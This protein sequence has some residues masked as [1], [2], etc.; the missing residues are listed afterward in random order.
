ML[1]L[2]GAIDIHVHAA[3][4]LFRRVGDAVDLA[5]AARDAGMAGLV[6][7][8]H[9]ESTVTRAY[10]TG[11]Q[12]PGIELYGGIVLNGFVGGFNPMAAAA[13]LHQ[14]ARIIWGPTMH[15]AHQVER[16]GAGT[17]GVG[18]MTLPPELASPGLRALDESG[19]LVAEL[20][21]IIELAGRFDATIATGHLGPDEVRALVLACREAGVRCL[22]T[23]VYFLDKSSEFLLEMARAGALLEVSASVS[24][25]L[26]HYLL[27]KHGGGMRLEDVAELVSAVGAEQIVISSDCG[28]IHNSSPTEALRSFLNAVKAVGVSEDDINTMTR[29]TPRK[30]LG[31]PPG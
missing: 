7:K 24:F 1:T 6:F 19:R 5:T 2:E 25:P 17:Y 11:L 26:E 12:V 21:E 30:I 13:A 16:F 27:R 14:G 29:S 18:H 31:E 8:A 15:A 9:H 22:L 20:H 23:H 4:E 10:F 28:Q 3:P